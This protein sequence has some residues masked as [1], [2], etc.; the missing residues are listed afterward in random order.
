MSKSRMRRWRVSVAA[1]CAVMAIGLGVT[2]TNAAPAADDV[3]FLLDWIPS[4]EM[5]MYY[6]GWENGT[7]ADQGINVTISRGYGSGDT[8]AKLAG[9][10]G[11]F[12]IAD[13][14]AVMN[15][16]ARAKTP[17]KTIMQLYTHSPHSLFVLE[18]SGIK[19]FKDLE[20][21]HIGI[22]PGNSHKL[23][24]PK[25]AEK[26][27]LDPSTVV[28]VN[29]DASAMA[30]MLIAK[31]LDAAPFYSVHHY[32][33]NKAAER[34]GEKIIVLPFQKVGFA[35]YSASIVTTDDMIESNPDL[36]KRFLTAIQ[37]SFK[38]AK[39]N[40]LETC[41]AHVKRVPEVELDDCQ[42]SLRAALDFVFSDHSAATG[43]GMHDEARLQ[44]TWDNVADAQGLDRKSM[45]PHAVVDLSFVPGAN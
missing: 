36:V 11:D 8:V 27:G 12:G 40:Q 25:I 1:T 15:G 32:Y 20:G 7:F 4:G 9:G 35:I 21:K 31:K 3:H 34:A 18:S 42:G 44:F 24:F 13:I 17:V 37:N 14:A 22:T 41:Q 19:D 45:D 28:W 2:A 33:Q 6:A 39:E 29:T 38:W 23:Y 43:M 26:S 16:Y 30:A 5:A 10:A